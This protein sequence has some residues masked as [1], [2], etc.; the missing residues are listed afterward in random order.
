MITRSLQP[1]FARHFMGFSQTNFGSLVHALYGIE[2]GIA[3]G[4]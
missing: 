3:R 1:R 4:L 2:D